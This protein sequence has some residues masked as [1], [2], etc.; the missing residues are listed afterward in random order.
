[1]LAALCDG[2]P[3]ELEAAKKLTMYQAFEIIRAKRDEKGNVVVSP[4]SSPVNPKERFYRKWR[5]RYCPEWRI[6]ELWIEQLKRDEERCQQIQQ[7]Q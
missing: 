5:R 6:D 7:A 1:M 2:R 3:S 4:K